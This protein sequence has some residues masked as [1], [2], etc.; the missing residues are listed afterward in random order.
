MAK[1]AA[2]RCTY[3]LYHNT[4][5]TSGVRVWRPDLIPGASD[6]AGRRK[7]PPGGASLRIV[8]DVRELTY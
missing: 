1:T 5:T 7:H 6:A 8:R 3:S 2:T 4:K